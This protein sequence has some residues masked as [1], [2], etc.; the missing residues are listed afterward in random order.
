MANIREFHE[1]KGGDVVLLQLTRDELP[2][3]T[4]ALEAVRA[5][6]S[7]AVALQGCRLLVKKHGATGVNIRAGADAEICLMDADIEQF[8][9]LIRGLLFGSEPGHQY[10]DIG[11]PVPTLIISIDEYLAD[12][13]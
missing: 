1:F 13:D 2:A 10:M 9:G 3:L 5:D 11:W 12:F 6:G 4:Q 7:A 8:D